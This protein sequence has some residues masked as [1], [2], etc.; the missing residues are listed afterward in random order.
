MTR[1]LPHNR[2]SEMPPC[3][4][5]T[6]S[7]LNILF[8]AAFPLFAWLFQGSFTGIATAMVELW[9]LSV[10]LRLVC[11]AQMQ[12]GP[13]LV[14]HRWDQSDMAHFDAWARAI[15]NGDWLSADVDPPFHAWHAMIAAE[16]TQ[17]EEAK[18]N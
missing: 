7:G 13:L 11:F 18:T 9:L 17:A 12:G 14:Q 2:A 15:A 16:Q 8:L 4:A 3:Q 1:A 5:D 10:A 6:D